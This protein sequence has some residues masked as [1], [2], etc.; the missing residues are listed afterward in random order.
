[1]PA[2]FLVIVA[3]LVGVDLLTVALSFGLVMLLACASA[4]WGVIVALR[5]RSQQAAPLMQVGSFVAVLFTTAYAPKE[6]LAGWL[7]AIATINPVTLVLEGVRQG[8]IGDV[9]WGETWPAVLAAVGVAG[10]LGALAVR[11]MRRMGV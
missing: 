5:F 11:S 7:E 10:G 2:I 8:W 6:L 1:M 3:L 9:T 4:F